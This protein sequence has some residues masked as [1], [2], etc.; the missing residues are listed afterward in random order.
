[1]RPLTDA[2]AKPLLTWAARTLLDHAL[3]RLSNAGVQTVVV[4]AHWQAD[5]VASHLAQRTGPPDTVL[6]PRGSAAG[7]RR[8]G[9]RGAARFWAPIRSSSSTAT[10]SGWTGPPDPASPGSTPST[11]AVDAVLLVHRTFQVHADVG[12]GDF[13]LDKWGMPRRRREREIVPYIYAGVQLIHPCLLAGTPDG[14]VQHEPRLGCRHGRR[15]AA[16]RGA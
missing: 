8:R 13:A 2:T 1:M 15:A 11:D 6:L 4:N 3:D 10:R 16:R 5:A 14:A 7:Y 12:L 9:P